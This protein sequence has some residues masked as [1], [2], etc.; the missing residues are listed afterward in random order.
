M[1]RT[2][3]GLTTQILSDN[4]RLFIPTSKRKFCNH[5]RPKRST[6]LCANLF[7]QVLW[8]TIL[9]TEQLWQI[10]W[11]A[12]ETKRFCKWNLSSPRSAMLFHSGPICRLYRPCLPLFRNL[13]L[14]ILLHQF[15]VFKE[16]HY[17]QPETT[18]CLEFTSNLPEA[19]PSIPQSR[20]HVCATWQC[21]VVPFFCC[22][23]CTATHVRKLHTSRPMCPLSSPIASPWRALNLA[24]KQFSQWEV[25]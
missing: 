24:L 17:E 21:T 22:Q 23:L 25:L 3:L 8:W 16:H 14:K 15:N 7:I 4:L 9:D 6:L 13:T 2:S 10:K 5:H 1:A 19:S 11:P 18:K 12:K 20:L